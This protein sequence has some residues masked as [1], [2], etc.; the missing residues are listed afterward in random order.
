M[1]ESPPE[2]RNARP[3][4]EVRAERLLSIRGLARAAGVAPLT[5]HAIESGARRPGQRVVARIAAALGLNPSDIAEFHPRSCPAPAEASEAEAAARLEAMGYPRM[6]ARRA[7]R[8]T[9]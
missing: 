2:G 7:V 9:R 1:A 8:R 6:L 3:L 4:R 5:I